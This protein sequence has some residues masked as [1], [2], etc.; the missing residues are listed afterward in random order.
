MISINLTSYWFDS[1][2]NRT[3]GLP[4]TRVVHYGVSHCTQSIG[5][6][7]VRLL[8][9]SIRQQVMESTAVT[10]SNIRGGGREREFEVEVKRVY[11]RSEAS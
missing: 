6:Y 8:V 7:L 2:G 3:P 10:D 9:E 11:L 1:T 5:Q 4:H